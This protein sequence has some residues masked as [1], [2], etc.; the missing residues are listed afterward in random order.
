MPARADPK[1][2]HIIV[3]GAGFAGLSFVRHSADRLA[4]ITI[5]DRQ[6]H[7]LFQPLLYQVATAGLSAIDIA[8]PIRGL[9][10]AR[11][12]LHVLMG[13][14]TGVD[15]ARRCVSHTRGEAQYDYLVL[16]A[17]AR[18]S[19]FGRDDWEKHAPGLKTI[20]DAL[21]IR[22]MILCSLERAET[23]DDPA[24]REAAMTMVVVG[25]GPTGVEL[26]GALAELT[27]TVLHRDFDHIDPKKVR[28]MLIQSGERVLPTFSPELSSQAE[29]QLKK[30]GVEVHTRTRVEEIR[31]SELVAGGRTIRADNIIWAAGVA[32]V[33]LTKTLGVETD[34][35]GRIKVLPDLSVPGHPEVFAIGDVAAVVDARQLQVPGVAQAALQMGRHVADLIECELRGKTS[36]PAER[37]AY[38]YKDKGSMAT[39]GRSAAVA[40]IGRLKLCGFPAWLAW[41]VVHLAFLIGFRS[42]FSVLMHWMYSYFTYKRGARIITGTSGERSA[43][44]A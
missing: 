5:I 2:P 19:Y 13:E 28:V 21:R 36:G 18:T 34:R 16:A 33:P 29:K 42:K 7:H 38:A 10:G 9:F 39:I 1:L 20:D 15:L 25:G 44:S 22:R 31:D 40:E 30:L 37:R 12:N 6:N 27:R 43:G 24:K 23:E 8:Q 3:I 17:G 14:V 32:A 35:A 41:L 26:A 11:P 4:H